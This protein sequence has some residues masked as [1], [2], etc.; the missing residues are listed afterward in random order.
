M[1]GRVVAII[2]ARGGSKGIPRKNIRLLCG[3][4]LVA[5]SVEAA[6]TS[7]SVQEVYVST[8]DSEIAEIARANGA[9]VIDRPKEFATDEAS[10]FDVLLH[11]ANELGL[12]DVVVTLQPTCPLRT[13]KHVDEAVG[14]LEDGIECVVSVCAVHQF[15]WKVSDGK[16]IPEFRERRRRQDMAGRYAEN[17]SI[18]VSRGSVFANEDS[19]LGMG[20]SSRGTVRLY[21]MEEV[22][23]IDVDTEVDFILMQGLI[24]QRAMG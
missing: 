19:R 24:S 16:G 3:K 22:H 20:I 4:P 13:G 23:S 1:K 7:A 10:T 2:P 5:Y 14:L 8:E 17:G 18:Y 11:A 12:P 21:E 6:L 15:I 9:D